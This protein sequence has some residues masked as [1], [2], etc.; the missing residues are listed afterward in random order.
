MPTALVVPQQFPVT[1]FFTAVICFECF[2]IG[3]VFGGAPRFKYFSKEFMAQFKEEHE[4]AFPGTEPAVGGHPDSGE[5]RYADKL[6]YKDWVEFN[7]RQRVHQ[8]FV[9]MLPLIVTTLVIGGLFVPRVAMWVSI[10]HAT[11]RILYT[12]MYALKGGNSRIIGAVS[13]SLPLYILLIWTFVELVR[14]VL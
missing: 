13:G 1:L 14:Q 11:A 4:D 8:N 6:P 2:L 9:E 12:C 5:G 10:I 3:F 7:N